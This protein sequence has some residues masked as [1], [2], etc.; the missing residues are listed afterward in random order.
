MCAPCAGY[1]GEDVAAVK[2]TLRRTRDEVKDQRRIKQL[3]GVE[4]YDSA[5]TMHGGQ[6]MPLLEMEES[7]LLALL[8]QI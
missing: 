3:A 2:Y 1:Y 6:G 7:H 4:A 5:G 8:K